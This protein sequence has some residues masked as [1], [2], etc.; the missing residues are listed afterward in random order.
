MLGDGIVSFGV[1]VT[2]DQ[3]LQER[4]VLAEDR[5]VEADLVGDGDRGRGEL[6]L[7]VG[8]AELDLDVAGDLLDPAELSR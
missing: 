7:A 6:D 4:E 1:H 2:G 3:S 5:V 8:V